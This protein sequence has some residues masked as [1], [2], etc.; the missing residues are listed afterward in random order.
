MMFLHIF[1]VALVFV[2]LSLG[3]PGGEVVVEPKGAVPQKR[4]GWYEWSAGTETVNINAGG[5]IE[6]TSAY[7]TVNQMSN[8]I[9]QTSA[10]YNLDID[11]RNYNFASTIFTMNIYW[12]G[13]SARYTQSS[14]DFKQSVPAA[15]AFM[16]MTSGSAGYQWVLCTIKSVAATTATTTAPGGGSCTV[17]TKASCQCGKQSATSRI[18][19]GSNAVLGEA[20]WQVGIVFKLN[21]GGYYPPFCGGTI[22]SA[23]H[24]ITA[25]HCTTQDES[26]GNY[27]VTY[28]T[29]NLMSTA[30]IDVAKVYDHPNYNKQTVANDITVMKLARAMPFSSTVA[31][32]CLPN[33]SLDYAGMQAL[34]T[35]WGRIGYESNSQ[36]PQTLQKIVMRVENHNTC[37]AAWRY[38]LNKDLQVCTVGNKA[39][40]TFR[41]DSGGPMVVQNQ[42]SY[43]LVGVVSYGNQCSDCGVPVVFTRVSGYL[44]W[45][46]KIICATSNDYYCSKPSL[47]G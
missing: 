2:G 43:Q 16:R 29:L 41:G 34:M 1:A 12:T 9:V 31:P 19:G 36:Q 22:V 37:N 11:C 28:G 30:I 20:P 18:V 21:S 33:P 10:G 38:S 35:G 46:N 17:A 27:G 47:V 26:T 15:R 39:K 32:A 8:K 3:A 44:T 42:G 14:G 13:G 5:S 45:I 23:Y 25:A 40:G 7:M 4:W 24:I 6:I